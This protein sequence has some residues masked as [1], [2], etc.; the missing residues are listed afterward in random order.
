VAK[1]VA[2]IHGTQLIDVRFYPRH[3]A[4]G[5]FAEMATPH[6]LQPRLEDAP[7]KIEFVLVSQLALFVRTQWKIDQGGG[8]RYEA[9]QEEFNRVPVTE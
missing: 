3:L 7:K 5:K 1:A 4:V 9:L 6:F 2:F 8:G